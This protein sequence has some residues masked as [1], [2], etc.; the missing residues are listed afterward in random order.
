MTVAFD[1]DLLTPM[2]AGW[3][4]VASRYGLPAAPS[5]YSYGHRRHGQD[6]T[7]VNGHH[8]TS[9]TKHSRNTPLL[10]TSMSA[11]VC[12]SHHAMAAW[13]HVMRHSNSI[14]DICVLP[15]A[16]IRT[17]DPARGEMQSDESS[18]A[19]GALSGYAAGLLREMLPR[20]YRRWS[21]RSGDAGRGSGDRGTWLK[22]KPRDPWWTHTSTRRDCTPPAF[23]K[24]FRL[25]L[26]N[27]ILGNVMRSVYR[28]RAPSKPAAGTVRC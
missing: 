20:V 19:S 18:P 12:A 1:E 22:S 13:N 21:R 9:S 4:K 15:I 17:P 8:A 11:R 5:A 3:Q 16:K 26:R 25:E 7:D 27:P 6:S 23:F 24:G 2:L 28:G 10:C 14:C